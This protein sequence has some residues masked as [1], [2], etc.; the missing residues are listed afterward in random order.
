MSYIQI[1]LVYV[2]PLKVFYIGRDVIEPFSPRTIEESYF[3][4]PNSEH[5]TK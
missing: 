1:I 4:I 3:E 5:L 2:Y